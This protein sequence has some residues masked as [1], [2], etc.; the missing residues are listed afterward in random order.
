[1]VA[2]LVLLLLALVVGVGVLAFGGWTG[3]QTIRRRTIIERDPIVD[4]EVTYARPVRRRVV[5]EDLRQE[6]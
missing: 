5:E 2:V 3:G 1:M 6:W 4:R